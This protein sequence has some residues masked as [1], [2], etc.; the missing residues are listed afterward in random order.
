MVGWVDILIRFCDEI[1]LLLKEK[2][3]NLIYYNRAEQKNKPFVY[4]FSVNNK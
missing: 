2:E 3:G 4:V 1:I